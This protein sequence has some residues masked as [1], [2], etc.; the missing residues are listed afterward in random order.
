MQS[1]E[2]IVKKTGFSDAGE[3]PE[4]HLFHVI[5]DFLMPFLPFEAI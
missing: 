3:I 1:V 4:K 5:D 2:L